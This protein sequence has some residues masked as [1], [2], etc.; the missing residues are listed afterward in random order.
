MSFPNPK[1]IWLDINITQGKF[2]S[3]LTPT[4]AEW[5]GSDVSKKMYSSKKG[6]L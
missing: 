2:E 1:S 5:E 3:A 4:S 6:Q